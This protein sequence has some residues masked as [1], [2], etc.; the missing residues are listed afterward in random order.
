[1]FGAVKARAGSPVSADLLRSRHRVVGPGRGSRLQRESVVTFPGI[2]TGCGGGLNISIGIER[3]KLTQVGKVLARS[4]TKQ[5]VSLLAGKG[6]FSGP[7]RRNAR[8]ADHV[9]TGSQSFT[10]GGYDTACSPW[11]YQRTTEVRPQMKSPA[12]GRGA[13]P[14][15]AAEGL[16]GGAKVLVRNNLIGHAGGLLYVGVR[17]FV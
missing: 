1:M 5:T 12:W 9:E 11:P 15:G 14:L 3:R 16:G 7:C 4:D 10:K 6:R 2:V 17:C 13:V 8:R